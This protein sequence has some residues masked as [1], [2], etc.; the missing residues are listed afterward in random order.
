MTT[1]FLSRRLGRKAVRRDRRTLR[2]NRYILPSAL[3]P[4]PT[5]CDWTQKATVPWGQ[6]LNNQL[7]DCTCAAA[8]H[9][10]QAWTA[11]TGQEQTPPDDA[12]LAAYEA[13]SGYNPATGAND[14]GAVELDV[15][16]YWRTTGI[17]GHKIGAF[18]AVNVVQQEIQEAIWLTGGCYVGMALPEAVEN[19]SSWTVPSHIPLFGRR[20]WKAGS[21]GGHAVSLLSYNSSGVVCV[22]WGNLLSISWDFFHEYC[23]EAYAIISPDWVN[24]TSKAPNGFDMAALNNDLRG[25]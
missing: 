15:L 24:D 23:D 13:V 18:A 10:I 25:L 12:I 2:F 17:A 16:N 9:L 3:P 8:G 6:M 5:E 4:A 21:W 22:T 20:H 19:A 14:N 1:R 11:N 7:S